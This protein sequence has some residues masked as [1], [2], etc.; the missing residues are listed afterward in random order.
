MLTIGFTPSITRCHCLPLLQ[1]QLQHN[2]ALTASHTISNSTTA[3]GD[4]PTD[5]SSTTAPTN[6]HASI[7]IGGS[8]SSSCPA[9]PTKLLDGTQA[10]LRTSIDSLKVQLHDSEVRLTASRKHI[11]ASA[12][13]LQE[14]KGILR[15]RDDQVGWAGWVGIQVTCNGMGNARLSS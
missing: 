6:A 15:M 9:S 12:Q 7:A 5:S 2:L 4:A 10:P 11:D 14:L 8:S 13:Q 3:A 1:D